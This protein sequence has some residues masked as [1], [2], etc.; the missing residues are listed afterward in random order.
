MACGWSSKPSQ[1]PLQTYNSRDETSKVSNEIDIKGFLKLQDMH[2]FERTKTELTN[3][4]RSVLRRIRLE[5]SL[6]E[7]AEIVKRL[8][9]R[10]LIDDQNKRIAEVRLRLKWL[11]D[12]YESDSD[13]D[14]DYDYDYGYGYGYGYDRLLS[15]R[16]R[17]RFR[18]QS[19]NSIAC[20]LYYDSLMRIRQYRLQ[21]DLHSVSSTM[22][23]ISCCP[24]SSGLEH[25]V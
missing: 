8:R 18:N 1:Y 2:E 3:D 9:L 7:G 13:L 22:S 21:K 14:Y 19:A 15:L 12:T 24:Y 6:D 17:N 10:Q 11:K 5:K 25:K 23:E 20:R 4:C 16:R